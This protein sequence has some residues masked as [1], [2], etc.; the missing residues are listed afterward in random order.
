MII[1]DEFFNIF[2]KLNNLP[3]V[4]T[5]FEKWMIGDI[6]INN[7]KDGYKV[8]TTG[9]IYGGYPISSDYAYRFPSAVWCPPLISYQKNR[10]SL[11]E[12]VDWDNLPYVH[13]H[14]KGEMSLIEDKG[15]ILKTENPILFTAKIIL[16]QQKK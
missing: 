5:V 13:V 15:F 12:M 1:N 8:Y 9:S 14:S 3:L 7:E 16:L 6:F 10:R 2:T 11:W 4:Q